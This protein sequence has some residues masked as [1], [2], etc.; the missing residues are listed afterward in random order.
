FSGSLVMRNEGGFDVTYTA[1]QVSS[2]SPLDPISP[3]TSGIPLVIGAVVLGFGA[4]AA[5]LSAPASAPLG[6]RRIA[7]RLT[8]AGAA[9]LVGAV[10]TT[11]MQVAASVRT[12]N[13]F[14]D[15]VPFND[16]VAIHALPGTGL[17]LLV[18]AALAGLVA[19]VLTFLPRSS[20][21]RSAAAR[22][23]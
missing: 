19:M 9:F 6:M 4:L 5:L 13:G 12:Y 11:G 2:G 7:R 16:D 3:G 21:R 8:A 20:G 14:R 18:G 10:W 15:L 17:W 1:W 22:G 23:N